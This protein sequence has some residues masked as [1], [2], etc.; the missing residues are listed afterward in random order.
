M[1]MARMAGDANEL[2]RLMDENGIR[3]K[4]NMISGHFTIAN[5]FAVVPSEDSPAFMAQGD[6]R[7]PYT[8]PGTPTGG[9]EAGGTIDIGTDDRDVITEDQI[10]NDDLIVN[11]SICVGTDCANGEVFG[12]DTIRLKENN[13]RIKFQDTSVGSFPS[14]D[15]QLTA[16]DSASGGQN[17][18]SID[19]ITAGRTPFTVEGS[20]PS[21]SLYVDDAGRVGIGTSTPSVEL[22]VVDGDSPTLRLQQDASSGFTPQVWDL[23]GN[24]TNLFFRD[25]T[26]GSQLPFRI[27]PGADSNSIYIEND[28][29]V[30]IGN[31]SADALLHVG[32]AT[33]NTQLLVRDTNGTNARRDLLSLTN[34]GEVAFLMSKKDAGNAAVSDDWTFLLRDGTGGGA[35]TEFLISRNG[36][37]VEEMV[38]R[39]TGEVRVVSLTETSDRNRKTNINEVDAKEILARVADLPVSTWSYIGNETVTHMGPMAQDFRAAFGLGTSDTTIGTIDRDGV[40]LAAIKGLNQRLN[41]KEA[42]LADKD[43]TIQDLNARLSALEKLVQKLAD[44][45]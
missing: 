40:A 19:D 1:E 23:A 8:N 39:D 42:E 9:N 4:N 31:T 21:H 29:N 27:R 2:N 18:F 20:A 7:G 11:F 13:L 5:G 35:D 36:N 14:T 32:N 10:I 12:F 34:N 6:G 22:H 26:N 43:A 33:G 45:K 44:D 30:A 25:V 3:A 38:V 37:G 15:W 17:R 28:N 41:E 16:N 24:E